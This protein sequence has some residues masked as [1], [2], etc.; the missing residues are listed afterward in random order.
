MLKPPILPHH[1]ISLEEK[2]NYVSW[3]VV[4]R[5]EIQT[6]NNTKRKACDVPWIFENVCKQ[7]YKGIIPI[8]V[9]IADPDTCTL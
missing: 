2:K 5:T 9:T 8:E 4:I 1:H 6:V 7:C 3:R